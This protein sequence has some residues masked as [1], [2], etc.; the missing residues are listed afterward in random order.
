MSSDLSVQLKRQVLL[1]DVVQGATAVLSA[2]VEVCDVPDMH[3]YKLEQGV[4]HRYTEEVFG[5]PGQVFALKVGDL[6]EAV[7][8]TVVTL[9]PHPMMPE[10]ETG[11]WAGSSVGAMRTPVEFVLAASVAVA[12]ARLVGSTVID[13]AVRWNAVYEQPPDAF[14]RAVGE[15]RAPVDL[16]TAIAELHAA[17]HRRS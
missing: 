14:L 16:A 6:R 10:H 4:W 5:E 2:L 9:P 11:T 15:Q 8:V 1:Q 17:W 3:V 13:E 12:L 7:E